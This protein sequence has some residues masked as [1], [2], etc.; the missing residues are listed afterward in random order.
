MAWPQLVTCIMLTTIPRREQRISGFAKEIFTNLTFVRR[1][2]LTSLSVTLYTSNM[3]GWAGVQTESKRQEKCGKGG[4]GLYSICRKESRQVDII[5]SKKMLV[6][7]AART[8]IKS[9][10]SIDDAS[11]NYYNNCHKWFGWLFSGTLLVRSRL[12][13]SRYC[14][15]RGSPIKVVVV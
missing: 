8:M 11:R 12:N 3:A 14:K 15:K 9:G 10:I 1:Y 13:W 7:I 5:S 6:K 2:I 4:G